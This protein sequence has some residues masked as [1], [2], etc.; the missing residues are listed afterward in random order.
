MEITNTCVVVEVPAGGQERIRCQVAMWA[1]G[2]KASALS[3][4]LHERTG[5]ALDRAGRVQVALTSVFLTTRRF[6]SWGIW[7]TWSMRDIH[8]RGWPRWPCSKAPM[9]HGRSSDDCSRG[10]HRTVP[11]RGPGTMATIGRAAAVA[12]LRGIH[13]S[14]FLAWLIWLFVHL[15]Y[16][17][18][19]RNRLLVF[20]QWLWNYVTY[21][22]GVRLIVDH[23]QQPREGS[24]GQAAATP[25]SVVR[26]DPP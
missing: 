5:V 18:G 20:V 19:F 10:T 8:C 25:A 22:R 12:D 1:A 14:G 17:V 6:S 9:R 15:M 16:L 13:L 4:M 21:R 2:V 26:Q 23:G 11:L 7:C 24:A 3:H